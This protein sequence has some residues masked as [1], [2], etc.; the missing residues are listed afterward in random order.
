MAENSLLHLFSR[1]K[2][3]SKGLLLLHLRSLFV[4][5]FLHISFQTVAKYWK[6]NVNVLPWKKNY[7]VNW[8]QKDYQN[9]RKFWE[10]LYKINF[11]RL[12]RNLQPEK[13]LWHKCIKNDHIFSS[14]SGIHTLEIFSAVI[15]Y[16]YF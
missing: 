4:E 9:L 15:L 6:I 12:L 16:N 2:D 10:T 1:R 8:S 13:F 11:Q 5:D 3:L 7:K 14:I